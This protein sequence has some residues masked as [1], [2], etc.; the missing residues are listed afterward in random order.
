LA[1]LLSPIFDGIDDMYR[2]LARRGEIAAYL[3]TPPA[4][5]QVN[6]PWPWIVA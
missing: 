3:A 2:T 6:L 4:L 1:T 5:F